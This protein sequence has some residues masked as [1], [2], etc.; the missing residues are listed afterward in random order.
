[1]PDHDDH[2]ALALALR[3]LDAAIDAAE[4]M[5]LRAYPLLDEDPTFDPHAID[6][7]PHEAAAEV[8]YVI[9]SLR[10]A[11]Q[12]YQRLTRPAATDRARPAAIKRAC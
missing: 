12:R 2:A 1:M 3:V 9:R 4:A 11:L 10:F 7:D 8:G 6:D 5:L